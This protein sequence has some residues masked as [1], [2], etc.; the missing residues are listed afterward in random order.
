MIA[1]LTKKTKYGVIQKDNTQDSSVK[2]FPYIND[3]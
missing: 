1:G 3:L 2:L